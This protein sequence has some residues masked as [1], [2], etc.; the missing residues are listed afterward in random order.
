[1]VKSPYFARHVPSLSSDTSPRSSSE[2]FAQ[3]PSSFWGCVER[4]GSL[5]PTL[6]AVEAVPAAGCCRGLFQ[7]TSPCENCERLLSG[8]VARFDKCEIFQKRW[9]SHKA[10]ATTTS[11]SSCCA[12]R[13]P[14]WRTQEPQLEDSV[15]HLCSQQCF[16]RAFALYRH[17][18]A[19]HRHLASSEMIVEPVQGLLSGWSCRLVPDARPPRVIYESLDSKVCKNVSRVLHEFTKTG[20]EDRSSKGFQSKRKRIE[21]SSPHTADNTNDYPHQSLEESIWSPLGLLEELFSH[22]P[23]RLL[24]STICLNRTTRVQVDHVLWDFLQRWP[25]PDA[26]VEAPVQDLVTILRP[27][28]ICLRRSAGIQRFSADYRSLLDGKSQSDASSDNKSDPAFGLTQ[29]EV[30]GLSHCGPYAY[31]AYRIFIQRDTSVVPGDLA[32]RTYVEYKLSTATVAEPKG[33]PTSLG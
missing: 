5:V 14:C 26:V 21:D 19:L 20:E 3:S 17:W 32:L 1:M 22:D 10:S 27:L 23:W 7:S 31:D 13:Q 29:A 9:Q 33:L 11:A 12:S 16:L 18:F 28:G 24:L 25:T 30:L 15:R 4:L 2:Y 8:A 6:A